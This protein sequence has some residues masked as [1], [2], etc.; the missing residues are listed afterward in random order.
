M[1]RVMQQRL[2]QDSELETPSVKG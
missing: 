1:C 2:D